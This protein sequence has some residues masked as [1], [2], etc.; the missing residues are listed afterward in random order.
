MFVCTRHHLTGQQSIKYPLHANLRAL[1][2]TKCIQKHAFL[3][4]EK[5]L[6]DHQCGYRKNRQTGELLAFA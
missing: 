2:A 6:S 3:K 5:L 4:T 1:K